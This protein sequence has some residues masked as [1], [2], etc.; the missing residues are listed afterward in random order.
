MKLN[1][2]KETQKIAPVIERKIQ[3]I[4]DKPMWLAGV[5]LIGLM[6]ITF[7]DVLGRYFFSKPLTASNELTEIVMIA[8]IFLAGGYFTLKGRQINI[9]LVISHLSK[10]TQNVLN[11]IT[12]F[13]SIIILGL[14]TWQLA[15]WGW[16]N[17][18]SPRGKVTNVLLIPEAPFML[19]AA[20]GT[21]LVLVAMVVIL[22]R[23]ISLM[24]N[25]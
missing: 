9:D 3:H 23:S 19:I 14:M 10:K 21:F 4:L 18:I 6:L 17:L 13:L 11:V 2:K 24:K 16:K 8:V 5:C 20:L 22:I 25:N 7:I 15:I 12:S 1:E